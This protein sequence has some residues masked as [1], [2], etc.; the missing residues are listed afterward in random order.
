M[1]ISAAV[2]LNI[3]LVFDNQ[4]PQSYVLFSQHINEWF[5]G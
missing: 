5:N 1:I 4:F 2:I 3:I